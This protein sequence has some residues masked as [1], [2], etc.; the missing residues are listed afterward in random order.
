MQVGI[1]SFAAAFDED[2]R[3]ANPAERLLRCPR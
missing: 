1:D 2:S 3:A